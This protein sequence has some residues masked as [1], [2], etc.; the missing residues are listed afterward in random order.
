MRRGTLGAAVAAIAAVVVLYLADV[1]RPSPPLLPGAR[2]DRIV[3][4][5][6]ER[7]LTVWRDGALLK[8]YRVA[9]GT[10]EPG[11]KERS[12]DRKT[13][14][15]LY[16]ISGRNPKSCCHLSLR[17]SYPEPSD[18]AAAKARGDDPGGNIMIHGLPNDWRNIGRFHRFFD[19]TH[20]C[21]AVTNGEM[22]ELWRAVPDGTP[23]EIVP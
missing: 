14:E 16:R 2:A 23:I 7:R 13:P 5:K 12:G 19:W 8:S 21:I 22:D 18:V 3:V 10:A 9:L 17:I 20:G 4:H 11:H 15:G 1:L 6:S